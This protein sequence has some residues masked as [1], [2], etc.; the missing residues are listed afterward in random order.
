MLPNLRAY[1][2]PESLEEAVRLIRPPAV[3]P[4]G[5]GTIL[6]PT[7]DPAVE[8]VVDLSRLGLTYIRAGEGGIH[9]GATTPLQHLLESPLLADRTDGH[10]G[11]VIRLTASRNLRGQATVGG[12]VAAGGPEN[13]L[14]VL[15]LALDARLTVYQPEPSYIPLE[16]FLE[17]RDD[18]LQQ[19]ALITELFIPSPSGRIGFAHVG[20]TPRDRPIICAAAYG[21]VEGGIC[22]EVRLALGGVARHP[23]RARDGEGFLRGRPPTPENIQEA[24]DRVAFSLH[25]PGDFRGSREYRRAMAGVL[26]QRALSQAAGLAPAP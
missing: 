2:R 13:P 14:L 6:L 20:R 8:E 15:L 26:A 25:P 22:R 21:E 19:G 16:G 4:L 3:V 1:H 11:P 5:G 17:G 24:A 10:M 18:L 23:L 7:R 12:T 9:I